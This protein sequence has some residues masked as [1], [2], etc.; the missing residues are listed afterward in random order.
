MITAY[1]DDSPR[2]KALEGGAEALLAKPIDLVA[3]RREIDSRIAG[4]G[5]EVR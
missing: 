2:R 4:A 1:G 3:L 5:A